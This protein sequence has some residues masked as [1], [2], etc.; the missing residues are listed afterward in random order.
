M[1]LRHS[2]KLAL[3]NLAKYKLQTLISVC[4]LA[5][6][7]VCFALSVSWIQYEKNYDANTPD[8][9]R[10]CMPYLYKSNTLF[11]NY[12][13]NFQLEDWVNSVKIEPEVEAVSLTQRM[14]TE[15]RNSDE[16]YENVHGI[17]SDSVFVEIMH[18]ELLAGTLNFLEN[19]NLI[20]ISNRLA[21]QLF[22][23][24]DVLGK[25][26]TLMGRKQIGRAHV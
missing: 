23:T 21:H 7:F 20:A 17:W 19:E 14:L 5:V 13:V 15:V 4:G 9:E 1:L 8:A 11:S 26:L 24:T 12:Q 22:E 25:T 16:K 3:R 6:G 2:L 10:L 18:P